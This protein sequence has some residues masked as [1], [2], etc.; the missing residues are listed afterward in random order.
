MR[1][2]VLRSNRACLDALGGFVPPPALAPA[3]VSSLRDAGAG[4]V[5]QSRLAGS[6]DP[7]QWSADI[8][9]LAAGLLSD[10]PDVELV[11]AMDVVAAATA[12]SARGSSG[13]RVVVRAQSTGASCGSSSSP[14]QH[15]DSP[16]RA[17]WPVVLR[18][19]DAV[20]APTAEDARAAI[21]LGAPAPRVVLCPDAALISAR[22]CTGPGAGEAHDDAP[23]VLG[24]SGA[25]DQDWVRAE[26]VTAL[27]HDRQLRLVIAS[28]SE[29]DAA[30]RRLLLQR[31]QAAGVQDRIQLLGQVGPQELLGWGDQARLVVATRTDP[32]CGLAALMAM[33]RAR[34]VVAVPS[35]SADDVLVDG[36]TGHLAGAG[37]HE[38]SQA[39][40]A[41]SHDAFRRLAWGVAGQ[42]RARSRFAPDVVMRSLLSAYERG[43]A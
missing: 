12:L 28:P 3:L 20:L 22:D 24:V 31:A 36:V 34:P 43:A 29:R 13:A 23:Y 5:A 25:P 42:E 4:P 10:H 11:H 21:A 39:I 33:H 41:V 17:L 7:Q 1:T 35:A 9:R 15:P 27:T 37:R 18:A 40:C 8:G 38:L 26:L 19:A 32:T 30:D 2:L 16:L 14:V 6:L